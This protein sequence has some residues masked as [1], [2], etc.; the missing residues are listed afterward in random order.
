MAHTLDA[1]S[2]TVPG[3]IASPRACL[4]APVDARQLQE[5]PGHGPWPAG[6][7]QTT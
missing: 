2:T 7:P 1:Q 4:S 3:V 6:T 5:P